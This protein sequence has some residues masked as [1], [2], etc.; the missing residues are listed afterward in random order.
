MTLDELEAECERAEGCFTDKSAA[1]IVVNAPPRRKFARRYRV[2][3]GLMGDVI[4]SSR[5]GTVNVS[6][7]CSDV[8]AFIA[9]ARAADRGGCPGCGQRPATGHLV[10]THRD[11]K[12]TRQYYCAGCAVQ[13]SFDQGRA[14]HDKG[15]EWQPFEKRKGARRAANAQG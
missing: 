1:C 15:V 13:V 6:L 14:G 5:V 7:K 3:A 12:K 2:A 4:G 8:R 11:G 10:T 9:R